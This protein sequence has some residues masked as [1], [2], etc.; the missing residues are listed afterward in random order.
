MDIEEVWRLV[1]EVEWLLV[2]VGV[3]S[4]WGQRVEWLLAEAEAE[5]LSVPGVASRQVTRA[6]ATVSGRMVATPV[7]SGS[8]Q[9][10]T[11]PAT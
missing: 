7:G 6:V 1:Q 11:T 3:E 10:A 2:E 9:S 5:W 4:E 8:E